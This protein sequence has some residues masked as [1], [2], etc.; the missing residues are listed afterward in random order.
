MRSNVFRRPAPAQSGEF[1]DGAAI[2]IAIPIARC[3]GRSTKGELPIITD[4]K[5]NAAGARAGGSAGVIKI[6]VD[7]IFDPLGAS[8]PDLHF[9]VKLLDKSVGGSIHLHT[10]DIHNTP[11]TITDGHLAVKIQGGRI[12]RPV[13]HRKR[14]RQHTVRP[15]PRYRSC[16][17]KGAGR[18]GEGDALFVDHIVQHFAVG[19]KIAHGHAA[20]VIGIDGAYLRR[21]GGRRGRGKNHVAQQQEQQRRQ[22]KRRLGLCVFTVKVGLTLTC[23]KFDSSIWRMRI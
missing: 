23:D 5:I 14:H 2:A 19:H 18:D 10:V 9:A 4:I 16:R 8:Q 1:F 15:A 3:R 12:R 11:H 7:D 6:T 17:G 22:Q 13:F 20:A 21:I